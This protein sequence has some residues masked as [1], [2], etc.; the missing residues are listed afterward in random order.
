MVAVG[1]EDAVKAVMN[2][3]QVEEKDDEP[4][5]PPKKK[6]RT[7]PPKKSRGEKRIVHHVLAKGRVHLP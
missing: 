1:T 7:E 4:C 5:P 3:M 2:D 6:A